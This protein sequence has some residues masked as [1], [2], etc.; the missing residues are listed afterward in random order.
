ML[1]ER[2]TFWGRSL[3]SVLVAVVVLG[4]V[5]LLASVPASALL[6]ARPPGG[7]YQALT[8][9]RVADTR[10]GLGGVPRGPTR[11]LVVSIAGRAGVPGSV[12]S[13]VGAVAVNITVRSGSV[14]GIVTA[15][16][17]G[18]PRPPTS[19]VT[20]ARWQTVAQM[21][22]VPVNRAGQLT[23]EAT[24]PIQLVVDLEGYFTTPEAAS[25]RGLF[26]P[27]EPARI[28]DSRSGSGG[29]A[30]GPG[31]IAVVQVTGRGD[32]P[33]TGVSAV[34]I[35]TTIVGPTK[36][37][38]VTDYPTGSARPTTSTVSFA[39]GQTVANRA[40]VP[41]GAGGKISIYNDSGVAWP[42]IDV[43][44]YLTDGVVNSTGGYYVP[45][46]ASRV[47]D[48]RFWQTSSYP[49]TATLKT[50]K[51][52]GQRCVLTPARSVCSRVLVPPI[53]A[54]PR[55]VA[56]L[57][58]IT[59]V[60]KGRSGYLTVFPAGSVTPPS[61]DV[62]FSSTGAASTL[63]LVSLGSRGEISVRASGGLADVVADVSGYFVLSP[64]T[65][66]P[67]TVPTVHPPALPSVT[68][69]TGGA[70]QATGRGNGLSGRPAPVTSV[71]PP[72]SPTP[73]TPPRPPGTRAG[74][75][76]ATSAQPA[77]P[78][79][80]RSAA[81]IRPSLAP[82]S[83]TEPPVTTLARTPPPG[84][85]PSGTRQPGTALSGTAQA[86]TPLSGTE[87][88]V[89]VVRRTERPPTAL[90]RTW[91][92]LTD[93]SVTPG[94]ETPRSRAQTHHQGHTDRRQP[95]D[96]SSRSVARE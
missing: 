44:G 26:N 55:P 13:G 12:M 41:V 70:G 65:V 52:A 35:N 66:R 30:V 81:A 64:V 43:T 31:G 46:T 84:V 62:N 17:T 47:V 59:A 71:A 6:G 19:N 54:L 29:G 56:A 42:V 77:P 1:T 76:S 58:T 80:L 21:A 88:P 69:T 14:G 7:S 11:R 15:Y 3:V 9:A 33:A 73:L 74:A 86:G 22:V 28:M 75:T 89:I 39:A 85:S 20:F 27:L 5:M 50:Q 8:P 10:T 95:E 37:G 32:V 4:P 72:R 25:T 51:I 92:T 34:V 82:L 79:A 83:R 78:L 90:W 53:T 45:I 2:R 68:L 24:A 91:R 16:P 96:G 38:Y 23:I 63:A 18:S 60:P 36:A 48:T 87:S 57:L 49:S 40:I 67:L 94:L 93:S 61:S